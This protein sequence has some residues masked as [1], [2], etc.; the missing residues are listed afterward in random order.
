MLRYIIL[1]YYFLFS[2]QSLSAF[3]KYNLS[4]D[5]FFNS[6]NNSLDN[7]FSSSV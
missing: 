4:G 6:Y 7:P 3:G 5:S 2:F 1:F